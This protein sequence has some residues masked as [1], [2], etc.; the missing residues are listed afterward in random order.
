MKAQLAKYISGICSPFLMVVGFGLW[1]VAASVHSTSEFLLYGGLCLLLISGLPLIYIL[2]N[3]KLGHISDVHVAIREQRTMPFVIATIGA[4]I[5][6]CIYYFL[7]APRGL[8][9]LA[10]SL[11]VSG[12]LFGILTQ[13]SKVSIHAAAY[14]GAVIMV[15]FLINIWLLCLL[16]FLPVIIWARLER[17]RHNPRQAIL[18]AII[19]AICITTTLSILLR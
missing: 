8:I 9:A 16:F 3:M 17:K 10:V 1:C 12:L 15:A 14:T 2:I 13:F 4:I 11:V 5:L 7:D 19:N 18:A 6:S